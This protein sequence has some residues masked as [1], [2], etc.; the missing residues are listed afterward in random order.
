MVLTDWSKWTLHSLSLRL[1]TLEITKLETEWM[2]FILGRWRFDILGRT[3]HYFFQKFIF[4]CIAVLIVSLRL[5]FK[6]L[7]LTIHSYNLHWTYIIYTYNNSRKKS[8]QCYTDKI[9]TPPG[10]IS[11]LLGEEGEQF[12]ELYKLFWNYERHGWPL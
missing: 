11:N 3:F 2:N 5:Q 8:K 10:I 7:F 12:G 9:Y 1:I 4:I 6:W